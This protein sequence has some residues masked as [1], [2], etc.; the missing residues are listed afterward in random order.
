M[1]TR[2]PPESALETIFGTIERHRAKIAV[3]QTAVPERQDHG[4]GPHLNCFQGQHELTYS[5][6]RTLSLKLMG[7]KPLR[8]LWAM[9]PMALRPK[10]REGG[11]GEIGQD[12]S[13]TQERKKQ[14][15]GG[16]Q[17]LG[18]HRILPKFPQKRMHE[19]SFHHHPSI[20]NQ[21]ACS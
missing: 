18:G 10:S 6:D 3:K 4:R 2:P 19:P 5:K 21:T 20:L 14:F 1:A 16:W 7:Y 8:A 11:E 12:P 17:H 9:F 13:A 15:P